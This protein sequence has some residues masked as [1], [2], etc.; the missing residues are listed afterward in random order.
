MM[1]PIVRIPAPAETA[2]IA[3]IWHAGWF[4]AHDGLVPEA[5]SR[6]RTLA[7]FKDRM[8]ELLDATRVTGAQGKPDGFCIIRHDELD[9]LYVAPHARGTGAAAALM[10]DAEDRMRAAGFESAHLACA[11][12]NERAARFYEKSGWKRIGRRFVDLHTTDGPF[13]LEVWRFEKKL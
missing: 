12:G 2:A 3:R 1:K 7:D 5:L 6:L 10:A 8:A 13:A 4:D 11:I 9:Q